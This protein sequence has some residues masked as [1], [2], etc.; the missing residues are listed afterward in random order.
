MDGMSDTMA[1]G[2]APDRQDGA[3][4]PLGA[5]PIPGALPAGDD[6]DGIP[7]FEALLAEI[8]KLSHLGDAPVDWV[9]VVDTASTVLRDHAKDLRAA[10]YLTRGL[11]D[12]D[13]L[14]G[15]LRG[16][17]AVVSV[18]DL[19]WEACWPSLRRM[20]GR[21][22]AFLWLSERLV[23]A[24]EGRFVDST[25]GPVLRRLQER[26][27]T[28]SD[29]LDARLGDAAPDLG[30]LHAVLRAKVRDTNAA[31][32]S[33]EATNGAQNASRSPAPARVPGPSAGRPSATSSSSVRGE[34][35][36][37]SSPGHHTPSLTALPALDPSSARV[38]KQVFT[39]AVAALRP[40]DLGNPVFYHMAR[41]A[42]WRSIADAPSASDDGRT[43]LAPVPADRIAQYEKMLGAGHYADLIA[44]AEL[45]VIRNPFWL[46]GQRLTDAA[47]K[48]LGHDAARAAVHYE[49][50]EFLTRL[51]AL[52]DLR[53]SDGTPFADPAT[54]AWIDATVWASPQAAPGPATG[55]S[56]GA[57][58][59]DD[60]RALLSAAQA[61]TEGG[62]LLDLL[63]RLDT[64]LCAETD[65]RRQ[66]LWGMA[67]AR[68][69]LDGGQ[70]AL[71][72]A[73]LSRLNDT[74]TGLGLQA[75]EPALGADLAA[76]LTE[77]LSGTPKGNRPRPLSS[78]TEKD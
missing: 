46:A 62:S 34:S 35:G 1:P 9:A 14:P 73:Q 50:R 24:L 11:L 27:Q 39:E 37:A 32:D 54:R 49:V 41:Y 64:A 70:I 33:D 10:V 6:P 29:R 30:S 21:T 77:S 74:F 44:G 76:T 68:A 67:L 43:Q 7:A 12:Q 60:W 40:Q 66:F 8:G 52:L 31:G 2:R 47:L 57:S 19:Y 38:V 69:C 4:D 51:P 3:L 23:P 13:G 61:D 48:A 58:G 15:M 22:A 17:E 45:S 55:A 78:S 20:R 16:I 72:R 59:G 53:F 75:W 36:G 28:L 56:G 65:P 18:V 26:V 25:D 42:T 5:P 71:A 63:H